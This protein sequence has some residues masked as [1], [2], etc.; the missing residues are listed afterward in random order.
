MKRSVNTDQHTVPKSTILQ[1]IFRPASPR[2]F[3]RLCLDLGAHLPTWPYTM[4]AVVVEEDIRPDAVKSRLI[5][6][7]LGQEQQVAGTDGP[8]THHRTHR[9]EQGAMEDQGM[10][11]F[12]SSTMMGQG[13]CRIMRSSNFSSSTLRSWTRT[14][15]AY[16][17]QENALS[18]ETSESGT[19]V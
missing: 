6:H 5:H 17:S 1:D 3:D 12:S 19:M 4:V 16:L 11:L 15:M 13:L 9:H 8:V 14:M 10:L 7:V 2:N 18:S